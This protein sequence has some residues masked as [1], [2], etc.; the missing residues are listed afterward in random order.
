MSNILVDNNGC[1]LERL[2]VYRFE[3]SNGVAVYRTLQ[4][5]SLSAK[6][7]YIDGAGK[8]W[9]T[10]KEVGAYAG[11]ITEPD[12]ALEDGKKY[13]IAYDDINCDFLEYCEELSGFR[14][15]SGVIIPASKV[16]VLK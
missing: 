7:P 9:P 10:C 8:S 1:K 3:N 2:A 12:L 16:E 11:K 13:A 15:R 4:D 5:I 6:A 14:C